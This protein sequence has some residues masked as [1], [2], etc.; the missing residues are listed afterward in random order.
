MYPPEMIQRMQIAEL[1]SRMRV[2]YRNN[3]SALTPGIYGVTRE[4]IE[5]LLLRQGI[6]CAICR[7]G[8]DDVNWDIDHDHETGKVRGLLCHA[9]NIWLGKNEGQLIAAWRYLK[10]SEL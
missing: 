1:V 5:D 10:G 3:E 6:N 7:K 8:L 2:A 4:F 9:C